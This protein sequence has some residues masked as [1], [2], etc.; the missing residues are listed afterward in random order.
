[1]DS[2]DWKNLSAAQMQKRILERVRPGSIVLMHNAGLHTPE[3]LP[4]L[5]KELKKRGYKF[6]TTSE[7]L[8]KGPYYIQHD[9]EQKPKEG[10]EGGRA[11]V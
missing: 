3:A 9:G 2:L 7:L 5:I 1:M 6:T 10:T 11:T 4:G 8:I